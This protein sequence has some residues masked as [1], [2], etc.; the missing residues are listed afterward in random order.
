MP[1][2]DEVVEDQPQETATTSEQP[3]QPETKD[4]PARKQPFGV[5]RGSKKPTE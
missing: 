5:T 1:T 3:A 4:E 2:D